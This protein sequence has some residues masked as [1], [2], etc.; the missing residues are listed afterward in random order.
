[1]YIKLKLLF[2]LI[3]LFLP[4][5]NHAFKKAPRE[6]EFYS[7]MA[8]CVFEITL[9]YF[10][11]DSLLV[12]STTAESKIG[13]AN[14]LNSRILNRLLLE[15]L[16]SL[17]YWNI[18]IKMTNERFYY[19]SKFIESADCYIVIV[20]STLELN[21]NLMHLK[22]TSSW[23]A[24]AKF[25]I[26][27]YESSNIHVL[28]ESV[29]VLWNY[30]VINFVILMQQLNSSVYIFTWFPY[31]NNDCGTNF[32]NTRELD[33]CEFGKFNTNDVLFPNKIPQDM[34]GC[35]LRV[36]SVVWP[37][38][39]IS[40]PDKIINDETAI[41]LNNGYDVLL[42]NVLAQKMNLTVK[43]YSF[44]QP[45]NFGEI[46]PNGTLTGLLQK[47]FLK[48]CDIGI[49]AM[50]PSRE[51][52]KYFDHSVPY[53]QDMIAWTVPVS[54]PVSKWMNYLVLLTPY[55][56]IFCVILIIISCFLVYLLARNRP[57]HSLFHSIS[58]CLVAVLAISFFNN[59]FIEPRFS[60]LRIFMLIWVFYSIHVGILFQTALMH[61][62]S[63][64]STEPQLNNMKDLITSGMKYSF[65]EQT[66]IY[67]K[68]SN[69][70]EDKAILV[71]YELCSTMYPCL[72]Q[73]ADVR[74]GAI[75]ISRSYLDYTQDL[76]RDLD[77]NSKIYTFD[78]N[79]VTLPV[80]ILMVKGFPLK[81]RFNELI[82]R[83]K[84]AG[85]FELWSSNVLKRSDQNKRAD[86]DNKDEKKPAF[87]LTTKHLF[88]AFFIL[89]VG[90]IWSTIIFIFEIYYNRCKGSV[91]AAFQ[92]TAKLF[93]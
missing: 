18:L 61:S 93:K 62:F 37:P 51:R 31:E 8:D 23:N 32:E 64:P 77:G 88:G 89:G 71:K 82:L 55:T 68:L 84:Q 70:S 74:K 21:N 92:S 59:T 10:P 2:N 85:L 72:M 43:F 67:F 73:V 60:I 13:D 38:Y 33:S 56:M 34:H 27:S 80:E 86:I 75:A 44:E 63:S 9:T 25:I 49:G 3:I 54:K 76:Y 16:Y 90:L 19:N 57:E 53:L 91:D 66:L 58:S 17:G 6:Y 48:K 78:E 39:V 1:M 83:C 47:L 41:H 26:I 65:K 29:T 12:Y 52:H 24:H 45:E 20:G 22:N 69:T 42:I 50:Y 87:Q 14:Y 81:R 35:L 15:K 7:S 40:P 79:I 36:I 46:Y 11:Y 28:R 5:F 4:N 30:Y